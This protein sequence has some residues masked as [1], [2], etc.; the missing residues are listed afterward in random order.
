MEPIPTQV[1]LLDDERKANREAMEHYQL[2]A[3]RLVDVSKADLSTEVFGAFA[4]SNEVALVTAIVSL[5][6][7]GLATAVATTVGM[8]CLSGC[9][10][11]DSKGADGTST[12]QGTVESFTAGGVTYRPMLGGKRGLDL[13]SAISDLLVPRAEAEA[14]FPKIPGV[15]FPQAL[16]ELYAYDF[17]PEL[18]PVGGRV[19]AVPPK[20]GASYES[21]V[22]KTDADGLDLG[23]VRT[24]DVAVPVGTNTGWNLWAPGPRDRD[25]CGLNGSFFPF[26]RTK[27]ERDRTGD[28]RLSLEERYTDHAGFVAAVRKAAAAL[29]A[30]R[31]LLEDDATTLVEQAEASS[32][33]K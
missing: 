28:P 5:S 22:P 6:G 24:L 25:L 10:N 16:N 31:F 8:A 17:G 1:N 2:R 13:V 20:K 11:S 29:V 18:K 30:D 21:R 32:V 15:R 19:R 27:A 7:L 12:V 3:R 9:E 26:A 33:L 14:G 4:K 23:G